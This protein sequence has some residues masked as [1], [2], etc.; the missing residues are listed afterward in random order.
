M[1]QAALDGSTVGIEVIGSK[2]W[3]LARQPSYEDL[4]FCS[5]S[6]PA[7]FRHGC[8]CKGVIVITTSRRYL[9][10]FIGSIQ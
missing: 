8:T 1:S 7:R 3:L 10:M 2:N 5:R 4:A 9:V 6:I